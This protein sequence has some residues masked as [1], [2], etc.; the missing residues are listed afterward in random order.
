MS[1]HETINTE[2][3]QYATNF[4]KLKAYGV[5]ADG[6][7]Q[8]LDGEAIVIELERGSELGHFPLGAER[9]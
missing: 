4:R 8:P 3:A 5:S 9:G 2:W 6:A 1:D 7:W